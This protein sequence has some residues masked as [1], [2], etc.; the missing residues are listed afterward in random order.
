[1]EISELQVETRE[2]SG[3]EYCRKIRKMGMV[4]GVIYG[5]GKEAFSVQVNSREMERV[6][7]GRDNVLLNLTFA[8][9]GGEK[10]T[11][12]VQDVQKEILRSGLLHVDFK[13]ISLEDKTVVMV[14]IHVT[15]EPKDGRG[16]GMV[17]HI[18]WEVEVECLPLNI[19]K[20]I[21]LDLTHLKL[22]ESVTLGQ[23]KAPEGVAILGEPGEFVIHYTEGREETAKSEGE[24]LLFPTEKAQPQVISKG[25]GEEED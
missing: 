21:D 9:N 25:K 12:M 20:S 24:E 22:G 5:R 11:V 7:R 16:K 18:M 15:A 8:G 13:R 1:M 2:V 3:K 23:L 10:Q 19:P 17:E 14:P 4:P 6:I